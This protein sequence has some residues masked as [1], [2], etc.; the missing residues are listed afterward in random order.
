MPLPPVLVPPPIANPPLS[1]LPATD[2]PPAAVRAPEQAERFGA[3]FGP[4]GHLAI[5]SINAGWD[6]SATLPGLALSLGLRFAML[7]R[8]GDVPQFNAAAGSFFGF[9]FINFVPTLSPGLRLEVMGVH[10]PVLS[11]YVS[12]SL[13]SQ[14][15]VPLNQTPAGVRAGVALSWNLA[16]IP[17]A[18]S[19]YSGWGGGGSS[20]LIIPIAIVAA[21]ISFGDVRLYVQSDARAGVIYGLSI[22]IGF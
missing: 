18:G 4:M 10:G 13:F 17:G 3:R 8:A 21:L 20:W 6:R 15:L 1:S 16:A 14:L 2:G 19:W 7:P 12:L 5:N 9:E 22:G 11:P